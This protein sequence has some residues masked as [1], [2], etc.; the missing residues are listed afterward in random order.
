[1]QEFADHCGGDGVAVD[2]P[3]FVTAG[4]GAHAGDDGEVELHRGVGG[5]GAQEQVDQA[6]GHPLVLGPLV[7][8]SPAGLGVAL[9]RLAAGQHHRQRQATDGEAALPVM[10]G[11]H[12]HVPCADRLGQ[13][14]G[15]GGGIRAQHRP[16]GRV[17]QGGNRP[18]RS[19]G[20]QVGLHSL[21]GGWIGQH[22]E[23]VGEHRR[24][25]PGDDP[26]L[27]GVEG[28][29]QLLGKGDR[30][31]QS[32][33][34]GPGGQAVLGHH[35]VHGPLAH[36][37]QHLGP[38]CPGRGRRRPDFLVGPVDRRRTVPGEGGQR[39]E[40][41]SGLTALLPMACRGRGQ[42]PGTGLQQPPELAQAALS[43]V[44]VG[45]L[46]AQA[47]P[48]VPA[49]AGGDLE[50]RAGQSFDGRELL[51]VVG[52]QPAAQPRLED[53]EPVTRIEERIVEHAFD[54][55]ASATR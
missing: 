47:A 28:G 5:V 26:G 19:P 52:S 21:A 12:A 40:L 23:L 9:Q 16:A 25:R 36:L 33:G 42:M 15:R 34:G 18:A 35:L 32:G 30:Q 37:G 44:L 48:A 51:R 49:G 10:A 43:T 20:Q 54:N 8:G 46:L 3:G 14:A 1:M 2:L 38:R 6:V 24:V 31:L 22:A 41:Q 50:R 27:Q 53:R 11:M 29:R 45:D 55:T 7:V 39:P 4:Q 17:A 13:P